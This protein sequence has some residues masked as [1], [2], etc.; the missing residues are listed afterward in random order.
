MEI[1]E[2]TVIVPATNSTVS[3]GS[4]SRELIK[5]GQ[6]NTVIL[7]TIKKEFPNGK[8]TMACIAWYKSDMRKKGQIPPK[9]FVE[10][11]VFMVLDN[12]TERE[13]TAEEIAKFQKEQAKKATAK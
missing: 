6:T 11:T 1:V 12:G 4:R 8:T 10:K 13:A 5:Q 9:G 2:K 7:E 3:I